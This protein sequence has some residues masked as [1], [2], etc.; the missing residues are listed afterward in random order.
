MSWRVFVSWQ[1]VP[2]RV[3]GLWS[4]PETCTEHPSWPEARRQALQMSC[5][6]GTRYVTVQDPTDVVIGEYDRYTNRW[7]QYPS[8]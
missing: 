7:R 2:D 5:L 8:P 3:L 1:G 4:G 6:H